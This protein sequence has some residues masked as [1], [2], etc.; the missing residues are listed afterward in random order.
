MELKRFDEAL[1]NYDQALALRPDHA[2]ALYNRGIAMME[3][4]RFDEA[5]ANY[6]QALALRPNYAD[7]LYSRGIALMGLR[8]PEEALA[9]LDQALALRPDYA[10]ALHSRGIA[11]MELRRPEEALAS[12][13]QAL[14]IRPDY[15]DAFNNRAAALKEMKRFDEALAS[16]DKALAIRPDYPGASFNKS[17]C[18]L[19]LRR[20]EEG[21]DLY[22]LRKR[23][24]ALVSFF[25][26]LSF[27]RP[28]WDGRR[29]I[30][31]K[32]LFVYW[33]QGFGDAIQFCRFA[34][35]AELRDATVI[36]SAPRRLGKLLRTLSPTISVIDHNEAP[37][38]FDFH[39]PLMSLPLAFGTRLDS[40]PA[41]TPYL[42]A[43]PERVEK[44]A[45]R[46][47]EEGF[48][49]GVAWQGN[50]GR[51]DASRSFSPAELLPISQV[52]NV[53]LIS[54][55]KNDGVEQLQHLPEGMQVETLGEDYDAGD[56]A[57][58]DTAA[59]METLDLVI[60]CD[61]AV[62]H[63]AGARGRPI[64]VALK[65]VPDWRWMLDRTDCPW[66]PTMRLFRQRTR[67][68][69][70]WVFSE[71]E[72]A[73]RER[74]GDDHQPANDRAR[75]A[76]TPWAPISWGELIDKIT[77]LEIKSVEIVDEAARANV[78]KEL[79]LLQNVSV[80]HDSISD[81]KSDL[82]AVNAELWKIEDAIREKERKKE[83]D[84]EFIA[85]ARSVYKRNDERG[86][87]KRKIS[88]VLASDIIEE[89]SYKN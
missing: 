34:R 55:Q 59:V 28:M 4:K 50:A 46:V 37:T 58:L 18:L 11:L 5:L 44:W 2:H 82:K 14:A 85:L 32:T 42:C 72:S 78:M 63:L 64:W 19:L 10:D 21:W 47:G 31:G 6:G 79:I 75:Q 16:Y 9:D 20:F 35:L 43:E 87:I 8:R 80:G 7:A 81:L 45:G 66:Y 84:E 13:D 38:E 30:A 36:F 41:E 88:T 65:Y 53:R 25:S 54:L 23:T 3:L 61:T 57:F 69:W 39:C 76:S 83:F 22:E 33:E 60:S 29:D 1:A 52:P 51:I 27:Q 49:I 17:L 74:M 67:D 73:L 56:D 70:K 71:I 77:I 12:Y 62:A 89:K 40:I 68:D 15:A 48:K 24:D 26:A 86:R